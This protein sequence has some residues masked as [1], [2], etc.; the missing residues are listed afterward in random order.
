LLPYFQRNEDFKSLKVWIFT[1]KSSDLLFSLR[2]KIEVVFKL[3]S[4]HIRLTRRTFSMNVVSMKIHVKDENGCVSNATKVH[5][6]FTGQWEKKF[7][8]VFEKILN[9]CNDSKS[10][11]TLKIIQD[12]RIWAVS[13]TC[14]KIRVIV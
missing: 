10:E 6:V 12:I 9:K 1:Q 4:A 7:Q 8:S 13:Q 3:L 14:L 2:F 5:K 11:S